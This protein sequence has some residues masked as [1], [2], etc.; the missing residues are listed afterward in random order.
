VPTVGP[1]GTVYVAFQNSQNQALWEN[2][3]Q[4]DDQYLVV[5]S[6]DG[7]KKWSDPTFVTGL[8]DGSGD[9][10]LNEDGRQTLTGYQVRVNSAGN[11]VAAPDGTLYL[12]FSDN[13][14]GTHDTADP[15]TNTDVFLM[16]STDGGQ[17]WQGP[18][19]V[20]TRGGDQWFPWVDVNPLSGSVG[21]L[22]NDRGTTNGTLYDATLAE[23]SFGSLAGTTLSTAGSDPVESTFFEPDNVP[24]CAL[25]ALFHG[26]YIGLK[27]GPDGHANA[28]W[29]DMRDISVLD[30]RHAQFIYF[31]RK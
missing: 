16:R 27:Y 20:D 15:V 12:T 13:R 14:N 24:A 4:F 22:Y 29:T 18:S 25:C 19:P 10:P 2:G 3:E 9:Y 31:G 28:V 17:S 26:D 6:T 11:I 8:E 21:V 23:G 7:G 1:D 30:G 5:K